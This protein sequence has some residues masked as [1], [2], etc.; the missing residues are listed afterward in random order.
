MRQLFFYTIVLLLILSGGCKK[1]SFITSKDAVVTLSAD[2]M[3]FD[4]V[5][6]TVG[7]ITQLFKISNNNNQKL[8]ITGVTLRGGASSAFKINVDGS[9]GPSVTNLELDA[10]DSMFVFVTV[11]IN[12]TIA[13]QPFVMRDSIA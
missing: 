13:G 11:T 10:H 7:S 3:R 2:T 8:K 4:T 1:D 12:P 6:T 5:F 9:A